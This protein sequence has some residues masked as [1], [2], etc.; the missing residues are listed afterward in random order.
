MTVVSFFSIINCSEAFLR[1]LSSSDPA[2]GVLW[3]PKHCSRGATVTTP[4][5][6]LWHK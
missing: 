5:V 2:V 3:G 6:V 1:P 4:V